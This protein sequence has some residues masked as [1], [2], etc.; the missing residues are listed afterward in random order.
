VWPQNK[1]GEIVWSM[2][3][4]LESEDKDPAFLDRTHPVIVLDCREEFSEDEDYI[5][6][7]R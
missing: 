3:M 5:R 4:E 7:R 6:V 1:C 2:V